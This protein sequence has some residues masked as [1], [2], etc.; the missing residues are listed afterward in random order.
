MFFK[1]SLLPSLHNVQCTD[2]VDNLFI[3]YRNIFFL[4]WC[5]E[6][7]FLEDKEPRFYFSPDKIKIYIVFRTKWY[8]EKDSINP[9]YFT[10]IWGFFALRFFNLPH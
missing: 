7:T 8:I 1:T 9:R 10:Y 6:I 4:K 5:E 3:F 2:N